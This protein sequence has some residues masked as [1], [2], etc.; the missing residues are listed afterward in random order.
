[1]K[2]VIVYQLSMNL[3]LKKFKINKILQLLMIY[4]S[5]CIQDVNDNHFDEITK[6]IFNEY[7]ILGNSI[8][9]VQNI[10]FKSS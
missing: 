6:L 7:F 5:I 4:K 8:Q 9:I 3:L 10:K 1:M 2:F